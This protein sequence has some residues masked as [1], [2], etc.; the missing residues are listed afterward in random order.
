MFIFTFTYR[1]TLIV[2]KKRWV[3]F[4]PYISKSIVKVSGY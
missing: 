2:G 3:L 4:P 1:N